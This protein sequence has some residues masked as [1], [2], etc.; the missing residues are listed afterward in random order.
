M[1]FK[2]KAWCVRHRNLEAY[3]IAGNVTSASNIPSDVWRVD[4]FVING[5]LTYD[6][7]NVSSENSERQS[8]M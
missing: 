5:R 6:A 1:F 7:I 8:E 3:R 2:A 4:L